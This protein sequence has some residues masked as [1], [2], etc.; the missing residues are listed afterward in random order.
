VAADQIPAMPLRAVSRVFFLCFWL[1]YMPQC[2]IGV[3]EVAVAPN[4]L[5]CSR[6]SLRWWCERCASRDNEG[7]M[8][9][10]TAAA[11]LGTLGL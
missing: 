4:M 2:C 8:S 3:L 11:T 7:K 9:S 10:Y 6:S 1:T 5:A